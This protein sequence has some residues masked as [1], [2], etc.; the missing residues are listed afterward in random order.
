MYLSRIFLNPRSRQVRSELANPYELHRTVMH[1]FAG[2]T[3]ENDR[4][5]FRLEIH[6]RSG[7]LTLLI[8]SPL[9]P[10][11]A[12]LA[13]PEKNYLLPLA[14]C[15]PG[16]EANPAV[17][18][19][20][21]GLQIGQNLMFR[22]RANPSV[23]KTVREEGMDERKTRYGLLREEDQLKWLERKLEVSGARL[24]SVRASNDTKV[25][26]ERRQADERQELS[27]LSV[28]FDGILQVKD[29]AALN[30]AL[31]AGIGSGKGLGFGL[32][33]LAPAR[34]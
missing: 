14:D 17:K 8:Q 25:K 5:L 12:F 28:Q 32:L 7:I 2:R 33:S 18:T 27:F 31:Q 22:L 6:P 30:T 20:N 15:P 1:A 3:D 21:L 10:D 4:V 23:K 9:E 13:V 11:W 34:G 26:G 16:V 24:V 19:F 29:P